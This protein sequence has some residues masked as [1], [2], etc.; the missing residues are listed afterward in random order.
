MKTKICSILASVVILAMV[1]MV[2]G[3]SDLK[4]S[5]GL[6]RSAPDEKAVTK[7]PSLVIPPD[8]NL[9]PPATK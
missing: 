3:C 4:K 9:R 1:T 8:Y 6:E 5:V 2:G 7:N